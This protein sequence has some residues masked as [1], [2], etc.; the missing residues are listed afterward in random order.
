MHF[1]TR[2]S[3]L[4]HRLVGALDVEKQLALGRWNTHPTGIFARH[5]PRR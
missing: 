1:Y 3:N 5:S 2:S 4:L